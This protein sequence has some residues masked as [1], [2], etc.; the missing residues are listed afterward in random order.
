[1]ACCEG[2][3][4]AAPARRPRVAVLEASPTAVTLEWAPRA[5][6]RFEAQLEEAD[7]TWR[8][9]SADL[10]SAFMKKKNL[11]P[12]TRY[13]FRVRAQQGGQWGE[14]SDDFEVE[15][16]AQEPPPAPSVRALE[17]QGDGK[18]SALV[19]WPATPGAAA[20]HVEHRRLAGPSLAWATVSDSLQGV[21]VRKKNLEGAPD[22]VFR[23]R[24]RD[25]GGS[26]GPWSAPSAPRATPGPLDSSLRSMLG[27]TLLARGGA[28]KV[29]VEALA[30]KVVLIYF[31]ASWCPPCRQ[32]SQ[33]MK[34]SVPAL[35]AKGLPFEIVL[36]SADR[37]AQSAAAYFADMPWLSLPYDDSRR[38]ESLMSQFQV[39]GI[40]RLVVLSPSGKLIVDNAVGQP[41]TEQL[42]LAWAQSP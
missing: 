27:D 10:R 23:V 33:I 37:D 21:A 19:D 11:S 5:A 41:L 8:T 25:A 36:C 42:V 4:C 29:P 30:G 38:R 26:W 20:Y 17:A 12:G 39:Q 1:M 6:E 31:S 32:A 28:D 9:L 3:T 18:F 34:Q 7:G 15:T 14:A 2:G 35:K 22:L 40:P 16:P 24:A 13:R